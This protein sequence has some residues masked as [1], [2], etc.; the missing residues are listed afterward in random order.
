M[1]REDIYD[2]FK[3]KKTT[4]VFHGLY[5]N[6]SALKGLNILNCT[7]SQVQIQLLQMVHWDI[8]T[9]K[10]SWDNRIRR[11]PNMT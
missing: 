9:D 1:N 6:M 5:K 4:F 7:E 11:I 8:N 3:L 2:N 10:E